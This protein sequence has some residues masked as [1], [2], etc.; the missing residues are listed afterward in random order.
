[1]DL[2]YARA[3]DAGRAGD[4]RLWRGAPRHAAAAGFVPRQFRHSLCHTDGDRD[5][6]N[7]REDS[8]AQADLYH[9]CSF[10]F[11]LAVRYPPGAG[12]GRLQAPV[13]AGVQTVSV[14]RAGT[15]TTNYQVDGYKRIA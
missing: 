2:Q 11:R 15:V 4:S 7:G 13:G 12:D 6:G 1:M 8:L 14:L 5:R 3:A 9:R 10:Q